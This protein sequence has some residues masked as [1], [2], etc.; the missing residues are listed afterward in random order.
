MR[1]R[2]MTPREG[3]PDWK[4][5]ALRELPRGVVRVVTRDDAALDPAL[6]TGYLPS[7]LLIS[8][9]LP[10]DAPARGELEKLV[11]EF[12]WTLEPARDRRPRRVEESEETRAE[13]LTRYPWASGVPG[14][15]RFLLRA[16]SPSAAP[17]DAWEVLRRARERGVELPGI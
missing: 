11:D 2:A 10:P 3:T 16:A 14:V 9:L 8:T 5:R 7:R 1:G 13:R 6:S 17:P 4:S 12:G 15:E